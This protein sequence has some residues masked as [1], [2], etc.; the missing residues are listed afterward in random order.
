VSRSF[1]RRRQRDV[2]PDPELVKLLGELSAVFDTAEAYAAL[3][4]FQ[5]ALLWLERGERL[6]GGLTPGYLAKREHW[7]SSL[8]PL[9]PL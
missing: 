9:R 2:E 6:C 8:G 4:D 7:Q 1:Q 3:G 5:Q